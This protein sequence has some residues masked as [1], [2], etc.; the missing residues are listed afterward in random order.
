MDNPDG[1]IV[2]FFWGTYYP[3]KRYRAASGIASGPFG[4]DALKPELFV[5]DYERL[6]RQYEAA[7]GETIWSGA[8]FWGVPWVEAVAG[9]RVVADHVTGSARSLPW[10]EAPLPEGLPPFD[11]AGPWTEKAKSFLRLLAKRS[12]GPFPLATT[13]MRGLGDVLAAVYGTPEFILRL[14]DD[15]ASM[16]RAAAIISDLWIGFAR[17]Q[18]EVIPPFHGGTGSHFYNVWMPGAGVWLQEDS[19]S[20]LSPPLFARF[21]LP[22]VDRV[23]REFDSVAMHLHPGA[24]VP[25]EELV[26]TGLAA[27]ELHLDLGGPGAADLL[28]AYRR[29]Q[30]HKPLIVWGDMNADDVEVLAQRLDPRSLVVLPVVDDPGVAEAMW[31]RLK[32]R[33]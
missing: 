7:G 8:A 2:G 25:I 18:L 11:P 14:V 33:Q 29:I 28:S 4:P 9:C 16:D 17:A 13:L 30:A 3:W 5:P 21:I 24:Y 23:T 27:I 6:H 26:R 15:P 31:R 32:R 20:L 22:H 10:P 19:L 12:A 1:P